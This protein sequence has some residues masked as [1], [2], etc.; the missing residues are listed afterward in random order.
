MLKAKEGVKSVSFSADL[1][2]HL[3]TLNALDI[4]LFG[5]ANDMA[6]TLSAAAAETKRNRVPSPQVSL[7][8]PTNVRL[9]KE[10]DRAL[11]K[12]RPQR[13]RRPDV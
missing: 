4:E 12:S 11:S 13:K 1:R 8:L 2:R 7:R 10:L 5:A 3:S 9:A 6:A